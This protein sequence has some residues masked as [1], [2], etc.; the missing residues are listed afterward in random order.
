MSNKSITIGRKDINNIYIANSKSIS[1]KHCK[2]T[3]TK[4]NEYLIED[5]D[6]SNGTFVND[7]RVASTLVT[8]GDSCRLAEF[9]LDLKI[10]LSVFNGTNLPQNMTYERLLQEKQTSVAQEQIHK[11]FAELD[12]VYQKY[13]ADKK[14]LRRNSTMKSS[15]VRA[16]LSLIPF[17]GTSLAMLS[18]ASD[19]AA[20][21]QIDLDE[22]FKLDYIC[23]KCSSFLGQQPFIN[24]KKKGQCMYC[25]INWVN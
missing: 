24:L 10:V 14:K 21:K 23:P 22:Q 2:I 12:A 11:A 25:K 1:G 3:Q 7:R 20:E 13:I 19:N 5:L 17:V 15:G 9:D 4:V 6:S 18:G 16:G 8:S